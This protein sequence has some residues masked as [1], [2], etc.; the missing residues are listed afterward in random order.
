MIRS[1]RTGPYITRR[2]RRTLVSTSSCVARVTPKIKS[3]MSVLATNVEKELRR[4]LGPESLHLFSIVNIGT[5][6]VNILDP[7]ANRHTD[8]QLVNAVIAANP[9]LLVRHRFAPDANT[10]AHT[11]TRAH[12]H[13][14]CACV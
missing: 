9:E 2:R 7:D 13:T 10:H 12:T 5:I 6:N 4:R 14:P 8:E 11:H 3:L 1:N